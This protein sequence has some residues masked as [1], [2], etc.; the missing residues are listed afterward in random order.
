M[1]CQNLYVVQVSSCSNG[2][3]GRDGWQPEDVD[4]A[5][6]A[7]N[8]S[9][10]SNSSN[11]RS[12]NRSTTSSNPYAAKAAAK[13]LKVVGEFGSMQTGV[14]YKISGEWTKHAE[15]GWQIK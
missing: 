9:S 13:W 2:H 14:A 6:A 7:L 10:S 8:L 4:A 3:L 15:F 11:A 1:P 5:L 12:S